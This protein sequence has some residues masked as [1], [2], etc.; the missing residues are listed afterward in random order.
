MFF[1]FIINYSHCEASLCAI[2]S[3]PYLLCVY[4][5]L[6]SVPLYGPRAKTSNTVPALRPDARKVLWT[7]SL[8]P[9]I[10]ASSKYFTEILLTW[11]RAI[12]KISSL[13]RSPIRAWRRSYITSR[14]M[15]LCVLKQPF[16]YTEVIFFNFLLS[17]FNRVCY[18]QVLNCFA[19]GLC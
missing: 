2:S 8:S 17:A 3:G 14:F 4:N 18:H 5:F 6:R 1:P 15:T 16:T 12:S 11:L 7:S 10:S 19:L 9:S 13:I